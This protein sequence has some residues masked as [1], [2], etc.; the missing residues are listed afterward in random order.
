[1]TNSSVPQSEMSH[2]NPCEVYPMVWRATG[3]VGV[4]GVDLPAQ[5]PGIHDN[6]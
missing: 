6:A 5:G 4:A 1:M 3:V 2:K